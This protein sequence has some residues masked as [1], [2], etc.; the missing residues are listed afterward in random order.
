MGLATPAVA[1]DFGGTLATPGASPRGRDVIVA[2]EQRLGWPSPAG[3]GDAIDDVRAEARSAYRRGVQTPWESTLA[4]A[5]RRLDV[6]VPDLAAVVD[7]MW[8]TVPDAVVDP[9]SAQ[10]VRELRRNGRALVLACN[11]QR[12]LVYR[13]RTLAAAGLADCFDALVL[14][15]EVGVAKP[16]PRFYAAVAGAANSEVGCP[17]EAILFVGDTL[18]KDIIGPLA[19]GMRAAL[20][21]AGPPPLGLPEGVPV[22][23]GVAELPDLLERWP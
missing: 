8:E 13:H 19:F 15:S 16:D 7:A 12:P 17:P 4:A 20:V 6:Q 9:R 22:I 3:L 10:A 5:W 18:D 2:L 1:L 14:S 23:V 11:T 21:C